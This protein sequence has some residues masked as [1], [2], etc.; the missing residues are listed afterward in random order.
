MRTESESNRKRMEFH[1]KIRSDQ[2]NKYFQSIRE[3]YSQENASNSQDLSRN[4]FQNADPMKNSGLRNRS[5]ADDGLME[6]GF[7]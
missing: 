5:V 7:D 2:K 1:S 3:Q 6:D 4:N